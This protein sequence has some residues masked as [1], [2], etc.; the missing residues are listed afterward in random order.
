MPLKFKASSKMKF[1]FEDIP[2]LPSRHEVID[3]A[4]TSICL[5]SSPMHVFKTL[6]WRLQEKDRLRKLIIKEIALV[7]DGVTE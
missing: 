1:P 5:L 2:R 4:Y 7:R 6:L 3:P